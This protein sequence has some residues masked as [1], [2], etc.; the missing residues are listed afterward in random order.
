MKSFGVFR[1]TVIR[2]ITTGEAYLTRYIPFWT[3]W[4]RVYVHNIH[5]RDKDRDTHS[6]PWRAISWI[7]RGGYTEVYTNPASKGLM[8]ER[9]Y[10]PGQRN[11]LARDEYHSIISVKPNTWTILFAGKRNRGWGFLKFDHNGK[12]EH[13]PAHIYLDVPVSDVEND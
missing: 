4:F 10:G 7:I 5:T 3:P 1:K 9:S 13:I 8:Q 6:H 2:D 12:S 11:R